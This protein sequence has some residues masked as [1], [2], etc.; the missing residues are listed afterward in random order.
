[1][2][3]I[4]IFW[5]SMYVYF[6]KSVVVLI[7]CLYSF[8]VYPKGLAGMR[9]LS[10]RQVTLKPLLINRLSVLFAGCIN[11]QPRLCALTIFCYIIC[12]RDLWPLWK[13]N[14]CPYIIF[15]HFSLALRNHLPFH[16][17]L[18]IP[19]RTYKFYWFLMWYCPKHT[20]NIC[21]WSL[22]K[23]L[24]II[25]SYW[26]LVLLICKKS[27]IWI[28]TVVIFDSDETWSW[29]LELLQMTMNNSKWLYYNEI[30]NIYM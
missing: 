2:K 20:W 30:K 18:Y 23:H 27:I 8:I 22:S 19:C 21:H 13:K 15:L 10:I 12:M 7:R 4:N 26:I 17:G 29:T 9:T 28:Q 1:M 11:T 6:D 3:Q 14:I 24:S 16:S 25:N 5:Y